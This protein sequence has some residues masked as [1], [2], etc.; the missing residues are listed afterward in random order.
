MPQVMIT[1]EWF[2]QQIGALYIQG[3]QLNEELNRVHQENIALKK[4]NDE[5]KK[6]NDH[7]DKEGSILDA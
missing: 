4:E 7:V 1:M 2:Q 3:A 5:L 6:K